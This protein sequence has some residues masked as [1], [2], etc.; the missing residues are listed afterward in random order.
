MNYTA[1]TLIES[2]LE[3]KSMTPDKNRW[4][5][6]ALIDNPPRLLR[7]KEINALI[8]V[9]I[10]ELKDRILQAKLVSVLTGDFLNLRNESLYTNLFVEMDNKI[11]ELRSPYQRTKEE[12][13][14]ERQNRDGTAFIFGLSWDNGELKSNYLKLLNF[15]ILLY[16]VKFYN[17]GT[18]ELPYT[19]YFHYRLTQKISDSINIEEIN[20][21]LQIVIDP[22]KRNYT[23]KEL[24]EN[25][26]Y[27]DEYIDEDDYF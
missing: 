19:R 22:K 24:I 5:L 18:M 3:F 12:L 26:N 4:S 27:P 2:I 13:I 20:N 9:F 6:D 7:L 25:Y 21:F 17:S 8:D 10:P 14:E 11:Q 16:D 15:K 1:S 23:K